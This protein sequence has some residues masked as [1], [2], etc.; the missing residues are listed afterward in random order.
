[1]A[2]LAPLIGAAALWQVKDPDVVRTRSL[3]ASGLT[4]AL[5]LAAWAD[6]GLLRTFEAH[7]YGNVVARLLG[8]D[9]VVVDELSAPLLPLAAALHFLVIL[10]TLRTKVRRF[11]FASTLIS[12]SMLLA[13]LCCR[14]PWGIILLLT[15]RLIPPVVEMRRRN[16]PTRVFLLHMGLSTVLLA[17]GWGIVEASRAESTFALVGI[18]ML[19]AGVLIR[20]GVAPLH[21]WMTDLFENATLGTAL[22][23]VTPM[24]GAY[25]AV[26]L[27]LPIAPQWALQSIALLSLITA[28]Y[29]AGMALVQREARRF[30]CYLFLSHSSLVLVGLQ[31]AT[32]IGLTGGLCV[33]LSVGISLAGFGLTLRAIESRTGRVSLADYHGLYEHMPVLAAFF[34]I[35][36]LA[37]VGFPGTVGFV[38][39]E[40][41]VEGAVAVYP[42][43][44]MLVVLAAALNSIAVLHAYFRLF[45]GKQHTTTISLRIRWP[46]R[47]AV[48]A[49]AALIIGGGLWPQ[50]GVASRFHAASAIIERRNDI[51]VRD[52]DDS[53]ETESGPPGAA[54]PRERRG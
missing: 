51:D 45:T 46:E 16:R 47:A 41:L 8:G 31:V 6:F 1:M 43:V 32:P 38:G 44:G 20:S 29:A 14:Q 17:A 33:W 7:D 53:A 34:L 2:I 18:G 3:V 28:V 13:L 19:M 36:G 27:V 11:P 35:T 9:A 24:T 25:A 48:L 22:L 39:A 37:S 4:L 52:D 54:A 15:V 12:E 50:P 10:S 21:C 49:L 30:F 40:L 5:T 26:R 23:F 42:V